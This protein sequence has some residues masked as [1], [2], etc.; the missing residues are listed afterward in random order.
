MLWL[1]IAV[2]AYLLIALEVI[3][4]KFLLSSNRVSHPAVYAFY[5]GLLSSSAL[6]FFSFGFRFIS[7]EKEVFSILSGIVFVYGVLALFYAIKESD[8]SQVTPV[9][10]ATTP[11]VTYFLSV[12]FLA[13]HPAGRQ[14]LGAVILIVGG[15]LVSLDLSR[16]R[17]TTFF[18]GFYHAVLAGTF[19]AVAFTMFKHLYDHD[20]FINIFVWTRLGLFC[21]ALTLL[22]FPLWRRVILRSLKTFRRP[23]KEHYGSGALFVATKSLGGLG[24]IALNYAISLGDVTIVNALVSLEYAFVFLF[25]VSLA[26]WFPRIFTRT[27]NPLGIAQKSLAVFLIGLGV[28]LVSHVRK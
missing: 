9:V 25:E 10:V 18:K 21:G 11:I 7:W 27:K 6:L 4:D 14:L 28:Y 1:V 5:S 17:K 23:Q 12:M 3:L 2:A 26:F 24:S 13:E 22:L 15:L 20:Q 8:A 19:L 16:R